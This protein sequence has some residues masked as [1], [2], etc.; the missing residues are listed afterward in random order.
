MRFFTRLVLRSEWHI[1]S[2]T[3]VSCHSDVPAR[4]F[5]T[6]LQILSFRIDMR[7]L[8]RNIRLTGDSSVLRTSEW[9]CS[10]RVVSLGKRFFLPYG[11]QNDMRF[12]GRQ[13]FVISSKA[14][15]PT[16]N[17]LLPTRN[18]GDCTL[19][20][21]EIL[22]GKAFQNNI[23]P[24][25]LHHWIR[26]SSELYPSELHQ[27]H[28]ERSWEISCKIYCLVWDSSLRSHYI[29]NDISVISNACERSLKHAEQQRS[30]SPSTLLSKRFF[31][32]FVLSWW[33]I[34]HFANVPFRMIC[35]SFRP[36]A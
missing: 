12:Q 5:I 15:G 7:N 4:N 16:R 26:D 30:I 35:V 1:F 14:G 31:T 22:L 17:L 28:L 3:I 2:R 29:Q 8:M 25:R 10:T 9:H 11:R 21:R 20:W 24:W 18:G 33:E 19:A 13:P 27:C 32:L 36:K 34:L 6:F 23:A